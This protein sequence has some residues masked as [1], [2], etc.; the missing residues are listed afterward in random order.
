MAQ[1]NQQSR[2]DRA[3]TDAR[4]KASSKKTAASTK[5][6]QAQS[7]KEQASFNIIAA[8]VS[9]ALFV[10]FLVISIN[11]DGILL[12]A[13]QS[14]LLGMIGQ[15]GFYFSIPALLYLFI[16]HT[17]G[18]RTDIT[19]RSICVLVFVFL[20]GSIYHLAVQNQPLAGGFAVVKDLYLGGGEGITVGG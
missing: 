20:C 11:P 4:K 7:R 1:K 5:K 12:R 16:I 10:L 14:F 2:A 6:S 19:M 3:V 18:R 15:A 13:I 17:F 8:L 9:A